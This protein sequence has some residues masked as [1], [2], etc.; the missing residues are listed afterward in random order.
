[1]FGPHA[2]LTIRG[3]MDQCLK[4]IEAEKVILGPLSSPPHSGPSDASATELIFATDSDI[5]R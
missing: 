1:M 3:M 2:G 5:R 4:A